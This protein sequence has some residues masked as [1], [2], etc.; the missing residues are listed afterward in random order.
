MA[1]ACDAD[2]V[3][4]ATEDLATAE[5]LHI[6]ANMIGSFHTQGKPV[7]ELTLEEYAAPINGNFYPSSSP[8]CPQLA[9]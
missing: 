3:E 1:D 2:Q 5:G 4:A 9:T 8:A 7:T 6:V